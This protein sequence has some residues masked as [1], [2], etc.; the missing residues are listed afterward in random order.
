Y[1]RRPTRAVAASVF[2]PEPQLISD[3]AT[4]RHGDGALVSP[5]PHLPVSPSPPIA[6]AELEV[7]VLRLLHQAGADLGEQLS[8]TRRPEGELRVEGIVETDQ[9]K[10]EILRALNSVVSNPAVKVEVNTV[11]EALKQRERS[12]PSS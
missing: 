2:E 3:G 10:Q 9:R 8:V 12:R 1:E 11:A 6:T 7:E 5:S 4:G